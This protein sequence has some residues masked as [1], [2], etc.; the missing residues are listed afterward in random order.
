MNW[1]QWV[2]LGPEVAGTRWQQGITKD[3]VVIV[4]LMVGI[5]K[6]VFIMA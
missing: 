6:A 5:G 2:K 4:I 1:M 3:K